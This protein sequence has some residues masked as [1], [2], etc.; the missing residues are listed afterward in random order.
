MLETNHQLSIILS[1]EKRDAYKRIVYDVDKNDAIRRHENNEGHQQ[2]LRVASNDDMQRHMRMPDAL[3]M[4]R[5]AH[6]SSENLYH[7][8]SLSRDQHYIMHEQLT[9][10]KSTNERNLYMSRDH[11]DAVTHDRREVVSREH[12]ELIARDHR[13][14]VAHEHPAVI[15]RD[16][17]EAISR[18][19]HDAMSRDHPD[20]TSREHRDVMSLGHR[21]VRAY[22]QY[23]FALLNER[24]HQSAYSDSAK[25]EEAR[26]QEQSGF[27]PSSRHSEP[28]T[29]VLETT[30]GKT[31][32]IYSDAATVSTSRGSHTP[33]TAERPLHA[34][35]FTTQ[36]TPL[37]IDPH[38]TG[39]SHAERMGD[40]E[41][42][43]SPFHYAD[44]HS[45]YHLSRPV[46]HA[47]YHHALASSYSGRDLSPPFEHKRIIMSEH[48]PAQHSWYDLH[49]P[50]ASVASNNAFYWHQ[51]VHH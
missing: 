45:S 12:F 19:H 5:S 17:H 23:K 36:P 49:H 21:D 22:E 27:R 51:Q 30:L 37:Y 25:K 35:H 15:S 33:V 6:A 26:V 43:Q 41:H 28:P 47:D 13:N 1:G 18:G 4:Q 48:S 7:P 32:S 34:E 14:I 39:S 50:A 31:A 46:H 8:T 9:P 11:R 10:H 16:H 40:M 42:H 29:Q 20:I 38:H 2:L 44:H 3:T 24:L